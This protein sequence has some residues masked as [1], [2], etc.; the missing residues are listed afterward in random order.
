MYGSFSTIISWNLFG[1]INFEY[2]FG[3]KSTI[4]YSVI[5]VLF[6]LLGSFLKSGLVWELNDFVNYLM[7]IPN[8][9]ALFA[10]SGMVVSE[11][12]TNGKRKSSTETPNEVLSENI[13]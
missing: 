3:K 9:L 10:L 13:K 1:G 11:L 8:A 4:V 12:K 6:T 2:L 5:A 7:V